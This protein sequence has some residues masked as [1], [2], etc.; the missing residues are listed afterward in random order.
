MRLHEI[1]PFIEERKQRKRIG[2][3]SGSGKGGTSTKGHKGQKARSGGGVRPGFEGGQMPLQRRLP[4]GGFNNSRFTQRY[5]VL[6]IKDI[7]RYFP[8]STHIT[9]DDIYARGICKMNA[10]VKILGDGSLEKALTIQAHAFSKK[11][12]EVIISSG[13]K[14]ETLGE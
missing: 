4:K 11:A 12:Q 8:E 9:I 13:G 3:G 10:P 7:V 6:N 14:I 2:R 5:A 1:Y